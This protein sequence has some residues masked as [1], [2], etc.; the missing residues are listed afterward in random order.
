MKSLGRRVSVHWP[1][2]RRMLAITVAALATIAGTPG[3]QVRDTSKARLLRDL[4]SLIAQTAAIATQLPTTA[5]MTTQALRAQPGS[6]DGSVG[7]WGASWGDVFAGAGYQERARY[8]RRPDGSG[9]V[10]FGLGN[11]ARD[12][13]VEFSI[14]S[15]STLRQ[16]VGSNGTV[17]MKLHRVLP[18][19]YGVAAGAENVASWGGTDGGSSLFAVVSHSVQLREQSDG[20]FSSL[21]WNAGFGNSRYLPENDALSGKSGVNAFGSV[22]LR[23]HRRASLIADWTG[24]DLVGAVSFVPFARSPLVMSVG[25]ADL[26][27]RAGDGM[28]LIVGAGMGIRLLK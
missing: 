16:G 5:Q 12:I 1:S 26:T 20:A 8:S 23:V 3:A 7:A 27:G 21:A 13:G 2:L 25:L 24:Q 17:S 14:S 18:G 11:P 19:G 4:D 9:S 15:S 28:R 10:G 6:S 22:G